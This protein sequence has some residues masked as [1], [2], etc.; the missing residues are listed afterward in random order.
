MNRSLTLFLTTFAF[1]SLLSQNLSGQCNQTIC[2][3]LPPPGLCA[4][5]ACIMC[6]PCFLD[7][8]MGSTVPG[9]NTC[10]VPGPFCGSIENNQWFAFM[11]PPSGTVTFNFTVTSC[12]GVPNGSGIQAEVYS[13]ADCNTFVS[14][15]NCWSPGSQQN[16]TVT[17]TGLD[18]YCT[19]YL[20]IDGW[21][22]DFCDFIINVTDCQVPPTPTPIVISGP[23]PVCPGSIVQYTMSPPPSANCQNNSNSIIW[24][25]VEPFGTIIGPNDQPTITVQWNS[26]GATVLN[27]TTNNICFGGNTSIPFPVTIEPI[28]PTVVEQDV[29]LGECTTC[30]G[31]TICEPG[32]TVVSLQSWLGC[33]SVINCIVNPIVPV[34]NDLGA[35]T[36][37]APAS[38]SLCGQTYTECGVFS[39]T[40]DNWQGCDS[41]VIVDLAILDP[42]ASI[43]PPAILDCAP[44]STITLD[45]SGSNSGSDCLPN[46]V[47]AYN[48]TGP[49]GGI[50]GSAN[51]PTVEVGEPGEYCL[52]LTFSRDGV[53]CSDTRCVTVV[54]DDAVPQTPQIT[55]TGSICPG[56]T[57]TYIVMPVGAPAPTGYT[58]STSNGTPVIG[59]GD[60]VQV[61]WPASGNVQV[62]VTAD[63]IC[64]SS[65]AACINVNVV[66]PATATL[67]GNGT[68]CT[69]SG[70]PVNLTITLT[71]GAP[72]NVEYTLDGVA[73]TPLNVPSSPFTFTVTT[74]GT[75]ELTGVTG[76]SG[77]PG[78]ASG[79]AVVDEF[80]V[81]T[82]ALSGGG[83]ICQ[84]SGQTV[85]LLLNFTGMAPWSVVYAVNG[86]AQAPV[87]FQNNPDTLTLGQSQAGDITLLSVTDGN[88]CPGT[89]SGAGQIS[90]NTA[91]TVSNIQAFCDPTNTTYVVSFDV[92]GG[93]PATYS[94]TPPNGAF[95]GNNFT[96]DPIP[97][98][99]GYTFVI[100]DA[101]DCNPVIIADTVLCNC[102]TEVGNMDNNPIEE[103][104]NGPVTA[105]YDNGHVFDGNDTL[106]FIL[107]SGPGVSI[108]APVIGTF[109]S[110]TVSFDTTTMNYGTTYYLSAV[111]GDNNGNGGVDLNDPC[112]A[113]AQGTPVVFYE[114]PSATL[115]GDPVICEGEDAVLTVN[116]TGL[117]PWSLTYDAG[118][119]PQSINGI[120]ANP[121]NLV[122]SPSANVT[123]CLTGMTDSN[124]PGTATGCGNVT[125]NTAVQV[126]T[127]TI[128]CNPQGTAYTVSFT[129][130]AGDP[131][132]YSVDPPDGTLAGN[133]FMSNPI[134]D[135][136]GFSFIVD[137]ANSCNPKTVAQTEVDCSCTTTVGTM[138]SAPIEECG[139]GPVTATYDD[140]N[141]VLDP[142]DVLVFILHT[143]SGTT[144][145]TVLATSDQ[146]TFG[147]LPGVMNYGTTYYLSAVVGNGDGNGGVDL[148]DPCLQLAP[149]TPLTFYRIP[150]AALDGG[151]DICLGDSSTLDLV[152]T[153]VPPFEVNI[154]GQVISG[155][156][157]LN[158]SFNVGPAS[159]TTYTLSSLTDNNCMGLVSGTADIVVHDAPAIVNGMDFCIPDTNVYGVS[160]DI[161]GGDSSSY[162][163]V[164]MDGTLNGST[165]T[166]QP[167]PSNVP[168]QFVVTDAWACGSDTLAGVLDCNCYTD[169]GIMSPVLQES[170]INQSIAVDTTS[171]PVLE[172][173]DV[174]L[175]YLHTEAGNQLGDVLAVNTLPSFNFDP[176]TMQPGVTYYISAV[177]GN[178]DGNGGIDLNDFCLDI[179]PGTPVLWHTLPT[180]SMI[181]NDAVCEGQTAN[182]TFTMTGTGPFHVTYSENGNPVSLSNINS[183]HTFQ[184]S[185]VGETTLVLM[186][187]TDV[188]T[189]CSNTASGTATVFVTPRP[190]AG[191]PSGNAQFCDSDI[192][193]QNLYDLLEGE[194][195]GG[196]W[197]DIQGNQIPGGL[198]DVGPLEPGLHVF[199]YTLPPVVPCPGDFEE[200]E[201]L[202]FEN[203]IADAG[204]DRE[205][206]CEMTEVTLGGSQTTLGAAYE[207][208][209]PVLNPNQPVTTTSTPGLYVLTVTN[210]FG[211]SATDEV[212]VVQTITLPE[213]YVTVSSVSCFGENDGF[214][215]VDS[216]TNGVEPYLYSF[217]GGPFT[218][219]TWFL[220]L[221]P[222]QYSLTVMDAKGCERSL[223][224]VVA[225]PEQ[226]SVEIVL[227]IE[228]DDNT[229]VLGDSIQLAVVVSPAW[230]S[231]DQIVW[232]PQGVVPCDTCQVQWVQPVQETTFSIM[233]DEGGCTDEDQVT[234]YVAKDRAVYIPNAFSPNGDGNNE[235]FMI[236]GTGNIREIKSFLVFNRWGE[237][238]Y[239]YHNFQ[240]NNPAYGWDGTHRGQPMDP[241]VFTWFADVE[242]IDGKV[243]HFEGDVTLMR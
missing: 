67:S 125:V 166:S 87:T 146:P 144:P 1:L 198:L 18:P 38:F 171:N 177:A 212:E 11:A 85:D 50:V 153:G 193:T 143:N 100:S 209:G 20:M 91:P 218:Q 96:S 242:F 199:R 149:G 39:N 58:W 111:V 102:T 185:P 175:Y 139:D 72:W 84:S 140:A 162:S 228:G 16:G 176:D 55:G 210:Q 191:M 159:T 238:V 113:I 150:T 46:V 73:Q 47:T 130:S 208:S 206:D 59:S 118:S 220:N 174:L 200:V 152:F 32:L 186:D 232:T 222:G 60:T 103:C 182:V 2:T 233:V 219:E 169:A 197:T 201:V 25:G 157:S 215:H 205:L 207:W 225:Q 224:F 234:V 235:V 239:E 108:V 83:A 40:C 138:T 128:E 29:C 187:V 165:F 65:N 75:Y 62:C 168:Y 99:Q 74:P 137:D 158:Y 121:Y 230:D 7:G 79:T 126:S 93:D 56:D 69:G 35:V 76:A 141:Q 148:S 82:A 134:P 136:L 63:N 36:L 194:D 33:D 109:S 22:G 196:T 135:S 86:N 116:F 97:S 10:D 160:F 78:T 112:L 240:P 192:A 31:L 117:G 190:D 19:Y 28:P 106:V 142:D 163:I 164:P 80:P 170:C 188:A 202:I 89:V 14:V 95:F 68:V 236:Y 156:T 49:A 110:P 41:T 115:N 114:V 213:P 48:W 184:I 124:C 123:V 27:V 81:P 229:I 151:E 161:A 119:G 37:C 214:I 129:I 217:N 53:E 90:I 241:A 183:P 178:N 195:P 61:V 223:D 15:S 21:A 237:T 9:S 77:C 54:Q 23:T 3:S 203:P 6:D 26:V 231:L 189:G 127:P 105:G 57:A 132:S 181:A 204:L 180:V 122:I 30:A 145:G 147:F 179:A 24:S 52:T 226:V 216:V 107:H 8:Y 227:N 155:I 71:G 173:G 34:V 167:Q 131:A 104:G 4:E 94:V 44:G 70:D 221:S 13:T 12:Q 45:G 120:N 172:P 92:N 64:G 243:I 88:G 98:G 17:A 5:D 154:N 43:A 51:G 133:A 101:N 42:Q 211:C 66:T